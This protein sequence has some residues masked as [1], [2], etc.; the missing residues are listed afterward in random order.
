MAYVEWNIDKTLSP[1]KYTLMAKKHAVVE[2]VVLWSCLDMF[3]FN[4]I[5]IDYIHVIPFV[6]ENLLEYIIGSE[7]VASIHEYY[8]L[9]RTPVYTFVHGVVDSLIGFAAPLCHR[10]IAS[11]ALYD[12]Q[13]I[14][15]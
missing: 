5:T 9:A 1:D 8:P 11:V 7:R 14:V 15:G 4:H 13:T 10:S 12:R 2:I 3:I 6:G